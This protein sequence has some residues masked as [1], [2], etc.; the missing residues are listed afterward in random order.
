MS[1]TA[2][3]A[4][5]WLQITVQANLTPFP[6]H[7]AIN[8]RMR[9]PWHFLL[10]SLLSTPHTQPSQIL[11]YFSCVAPNHIALRASFFCLAC[12]SFRF[13]FFVSGSLTSQHTKAIISASKTWGFSHN[14]V[15]SHLSV[16]IWLAACAGTRLVWSFTKPEVVP[17]RILGYLTHLNWLETGLMR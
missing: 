14:G 4:L 9:A 3:L 17:S 1:V 7:S 6:R 8:V 2:F 10:S 13:L 16:T 5:L 15:W 12:S 11:F